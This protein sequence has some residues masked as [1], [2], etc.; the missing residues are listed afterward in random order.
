M[1]ALVGPHLEIYPVWPDW[2]IFES[3]SVAINFLTKVAQ[4]FGY[5]GAIWKV[6]LINK[7]HLW[8]I[9]GQSLKKILPLFIPTSGH[10]D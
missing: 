8:L 5:F 4:I 3:F 1:K 2:T 10:S 9:F 7:K 6:T